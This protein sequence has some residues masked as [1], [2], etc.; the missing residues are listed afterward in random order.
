MGGALEPQTKRAASETLRV[1][2]GLGSGADSQDKARGTEAIGAT[3]AAGAVGDSRATR[4]A[5]E[6]V[7]FLPLPLQGRGP[8]DPTSAAEGTPTRCTPLP[9]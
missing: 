4:E 8:V 9:T 6:S 2:R 3:R 5:G 1:K 7:S